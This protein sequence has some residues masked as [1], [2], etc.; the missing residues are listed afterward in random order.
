MRVSKFGR[1]GVLVWPVAVG[2]L[3]LA[4]CGSDTASEPSRTTLSLSS[5]STAFVVKPA[6]TT[7]PAAEGV[8]LDGTNPLEQEYTVKPGDYPL[9]VAQEFGVPLDDLVA[10]NGWASPQEFP[11]PG[12]VIKIPPGGKVPGAAAT[13]AEPATDATGAE[14]VGDSIPEAG[15][16]CAAGEHIV[17]S[18]DFPLSLARKYDV[19]LEALEAANASNPAY[20]QFIPGQKIIIP[21][22][23]NC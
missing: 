22:K 3:V 9:K 13:T 20:T 23:A 11:F 18:G 17:V 7:V 14:P 15:D 1:V 19:T 5:G 10:V 8:V 6:V 16:N 21:A 2:V 12:T 4:S